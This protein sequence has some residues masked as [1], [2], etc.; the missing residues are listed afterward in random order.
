MTTLTQVRLIFGPRG[1]IPTPRHDEA[2]LALTVYEEDGDRLEAQRP[3]WANLFGYRR[4][5]PDGLA[6]V[7]DGQP[8]R[9][10]DLVLVL[11][12][13]LRSLAAAGQLYFQPDPRCRVVPRL[14]CVRKE[15]A[16]G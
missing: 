7:A 12:P 16:G 11:T 15:V 10:L 5:Q 8:V 4:V 3:G 6:N 1:G 14:L 2:P 9:L 13:E